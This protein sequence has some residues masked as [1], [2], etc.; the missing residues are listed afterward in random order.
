MMQITN[1]ISYI[2]ATDNPLSADIGIIDGNKYCWIFDVGN[3]EEARLKLSDIQKPKAVVLSHFHP[4]HIGNL[5]KISWDKLYCSDNTFKYTKYGEII[6]TDFFFE[7][8]VSLHLFKI[9]SCHARGCI[10][11]EIDGTYAFWGDAAYCTS[12]GGN[13]V[14]NTQ[15]LLEQIRLLKKISAKYILLSHKENL[16][17]EKDSLLKFLC[18]IYD[19]RIQGEP[20]IHM[21]Y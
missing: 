17:H 16:I 8:G 14:Y 11:M 18:S 6:N 20:Y 2:K 21:Y 7:D 4:D 9:P 13:S 12:K 15:L 10:G 1:K 19:K 3:C 5:D